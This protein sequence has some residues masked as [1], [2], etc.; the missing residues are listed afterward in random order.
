MSAGRA[1]AE[2]RFLTFKEYKD[3]G[4]Y[5]NGSRPR[6]FNL[7]Q[8][9]PGQ[10]SA[11]EADL[12]YT[13]GKI[14]HC[15]PADNN[16][17]IATTESFYGTASRM[18]LTGQSWYGANPLEQKRCLFTQ[19]RTLAVQKSTS[20]NRKDKKLGQRALVF[21]SLTFLDWEKDQLQ[22]AKINQGAKKR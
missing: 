14:L 19:G 3:T 4:S 22:E 13:L 1:H 7:H 16:T 12:E 15:F 8:C 17:L 18:F 21:N 9:D 10:S 6:S 5:P 2:S 20:Q 11:F